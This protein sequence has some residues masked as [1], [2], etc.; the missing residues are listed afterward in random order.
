[1]STVRAGRKRKGTTTV[2]FA[3]IVAV[4]FLFMFGVMEYARLLMTIELVNNAAREGARSAVVSQSTLTTAQ[5][6]TIV[7]NS[8]G[9]ETTQLSN[10]NIQVYQV[11]PAN[12]SNVGAWPGATF[13]Q[14]IAVQVT[15]TY[16]P[17]LPSPTFLHVGS[18]IPIQSTVV[19][20]SEAD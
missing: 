6:Q 17:L 1:M 18:T 4:F 14:P 16:S 15:A 20:Y 8:L 12:G 5:I 3:F 19:M 11:N 10:L 2:E 9:G 7:T 13:G